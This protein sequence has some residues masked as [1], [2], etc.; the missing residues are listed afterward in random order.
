MVLLGFTGFYRSFLGNTG[1][2]RFST[3]YTGFYWVSMDSAGFERVL[4][5]FTG[6]LLG[7]HRLYWILPCLDRFYLVSIG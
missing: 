2:S 5:G 3:G 7:F 4:I 6:F 1:F